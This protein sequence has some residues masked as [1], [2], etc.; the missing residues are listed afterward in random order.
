MK[1]YSKDQDLAKREDVMFP[2]WELRSL[3]SRI[4][5]ILILQRELHDWR[6]AF[7]RIFLPS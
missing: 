6:E 7:P 2:G 4:L 5:I 1:T 3:V